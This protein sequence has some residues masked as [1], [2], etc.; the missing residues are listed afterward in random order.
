MKKLLIFAGISG[1]AAAIAIFFASEN[2][3]YGDFNDEANYVSDA[4]MEAYDINE[5]TGPAERVF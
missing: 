1:L 5:N 4:D 2:D 3:K